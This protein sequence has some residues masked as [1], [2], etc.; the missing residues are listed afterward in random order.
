MRIEKIVEIL[1]LMWAAGILRWSATQILDFYGMVSVGADKFYKLIPKT[2]VNFMVV[3][4]KTQSWLTVVKIPSLHLGRNLPPKRTNTLKNSAPWISI[5]HGR[6][7]A[8]LCFE[9]EFKAGLKDERGKAHPSTGQIDSGA[10]RHFPLKIE[11]FGSVPRKQGKFAHATLMLGH[12]GFRKSMRIFAHFQ[13]RWLPDER[14][15]LP[16]WYSSDVHSRDPRFTPNSGRFINR[17]AGEMGHKESSN[18]SCQIGWTRQHI[19]R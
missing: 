7:G 3:L 17:Y 15:C 14:Y 8:A 12:M 5:S 11:K 10:W 9:E 2:D 19:V 4:L 6:Q 18:S 13:E 1:I 16:R